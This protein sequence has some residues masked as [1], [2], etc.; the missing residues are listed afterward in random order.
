MP[1]SAPLSPPS[2]AVKLSGDVARHRAATGLLMFLLAVPLSWWLFDRL[3]VTWARIMPLEGSAFMGAATLLGAALALAPLVA[4]VG[5]ALALWHGVESVYLPRRRPSPGLDRVIVGGGLLV[6]FAPVLGALASVGIALSR[7]RIH[8][9]RPPRDYL[10]ATDPIA[11]WQ[12]IGFW[13][14]MGSLFAFLAWRYWRNKLR[15]GAAAAR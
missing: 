2:P 3:P 13:L 7:G 12:G 8:F 4:I 5:F 9:V 1:N 10:L 11:F 15:P 6:W 14:I